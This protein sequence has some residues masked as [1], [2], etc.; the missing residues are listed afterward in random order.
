MTKKLLIWTVLI[1]STI[2]WVAPSSEAA[3]LTLTSA[4]NKAGRQRMLTQRIVKSYA[5]MGAGVMVGLAQKQLSE[6]LDLFA[7]QLAEIKKFVNSAE[8]AHL[9]LQ[10][11]KTWQPFNTLATSPVSH[12]NGRK[13]H[14][15]G[16]EL[17]AK[18]HKLVVLLQ[19]ISKKPYTRLVNI[20]G[21]QRMLSQRLS[22]LYF[23]HAWGLG[24]PSDVEDSERSKNEFKGALSNLQ[25]APENTQEI[26]DYLELVNIQWNWFE[27][28]LDMRDSKSFQLII[29]ETGEKILIS[30]D[31]ITELYKN[32][33]VN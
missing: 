31:N 28:A 3:D 22:K 21:R 15:L 5:Q 2:V 29:A 17:L 6:A 4:V 25:S 12:E 13:L 8:A 7:N 27:S 11:E 16:E 20:S 33:S 32:L 9:V 14:D 10:I 23:M 18:S 19:N 24:T 1:F 26:N 30:M